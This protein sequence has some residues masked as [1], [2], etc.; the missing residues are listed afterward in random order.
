MGIKDLVERLS[1]YNLFNYFFPGLVFVAILR[2]TTHFN[3]YQE[4]VLIGVF[5]YYF[6]GLIIS[7]IGSIVIESVLWKTGFVKRID[8]PNL[9]KIIKDNVK[10]ELLYEVSNMYRTI[11]SMFLVLIGLKGYDI[12]KHH[13]FSHRNLSHLLLGILLF[14]L[15][16]FA[17]RKQ[18]GYVYKC[19][20][21]EPGK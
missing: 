20:K 15:F 14:I 21:D 3:F 11:T 9:I 17:F 13:D 6:I 8:I 18:N 4:D 16:L 12:I 10:I 1:S 19:V 2:G 5:L 7:R